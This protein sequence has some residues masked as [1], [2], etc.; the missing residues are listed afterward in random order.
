MNAPSDAYPGS[1]FSLTDHEI[2]VVTARDEG[3]DSGQIATWIMPATLVPDHPRVAVVISQ[4]NFTHSLLAVSGSF[5]LNL[6]SD[7][8][9]ELLPLFG[10]HS[11]RERDKFAGMEIAR[12]PEGIVVL[13]GTC[14][15]AECRVVAS[16]DL[17]DR[18]IYAADIVAQELHP[19]RRPLHKREAFA[20]QPPDILAQLEDKH[21]IDGD[22]DK[23][24]IRNFGH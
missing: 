22:R 3:Q 16:L 15:W 18:I 10:L 8:Q 13:P 14:G 23:A 20:L 11:T 4:Q 1:L 2:F 24:F 7:E 6:L 5:V 19:G 9:H 12:S 21:R 17:G